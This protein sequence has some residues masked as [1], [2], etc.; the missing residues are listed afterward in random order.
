WVVGCDGA[1]SFVREAMAGTVTDL[2]FTSEWLTCDVVMNEPRDFVPNNLQVCDP[3]RPAT[4]VSAGPGHRRWEFMRLPGEP[5]DEFVRADTAWRLL[6]AFG[7]TP[8]SA[9]LR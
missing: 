5:L 1:N 4:A 7:L 8:A 6:G 9:T 2:G 3:A